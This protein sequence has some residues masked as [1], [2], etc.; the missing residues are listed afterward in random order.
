M[1]KGDYKERK[2]IAKSG[3]QVTDKIVVSTSGTEYVIGP[4]MGQGGVAR[5][6]R[7][8]R[9]TDGKEFAFKEYV[10]TPERMKI[11][12][13]IKKNLQTLIKI[14]CWIKIERL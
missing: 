4:K 8:R 10:P 12:R 6:F 13:E 1:E 14:R 9:V 5:V 7:A 11:H 3:K 2:R